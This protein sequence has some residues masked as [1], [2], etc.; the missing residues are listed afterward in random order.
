MWTACISSLSEVSEREYNI[1][2]KTMPFGYVGYENTMQELI[3]YIR[4]HDD[5]YEK[6]H[7]EEA[8]E[9][10]SGI[11]YYLTIKSLYY[12]RRVEFE[13]YDLENLDGCCN[14]AKEDL[15]EARELAK[16]A[17]IRDKQSTLRHEIEL[18]KKEIEKLEKQH[19]EAEAEWYRLRSA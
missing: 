15:L 19:N 6:L 7:L 12:N 2:C 13:L 9:N 18:R 10:E 5:G 16:M 14:L 8:S 17:V 1:L 4:N 3:D 11:R